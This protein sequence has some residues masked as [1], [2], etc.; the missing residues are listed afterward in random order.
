MIL[1]VDDSKEF[2]VID[3]CTSQ[4]YEQIKISYTRKV[5]NYKFNPRVKA[6]TWDGNISFI[7]GKTLPAST[8]KYLFDMCTEFGFDCEITNIET[9]F[10]NDIDYDEFVE[11]VNDFFKDN[12]IKPRYY[13]VD[14]AYQMLRAKRCCIML[15]TSAGKTLISFITISYLLTH[16]L[17]KKV[18]MIV[19]KIDLVLQ[20]TSDFKE[21]NNGKLDIKIQQIYSGCKVQPDANIYIGTYQSLC[22]ECQ[23]YFDQFDAVISDEVHLS[24]SA[25]QIKIMDMCKFPYR[26][27]LSGTIPT[28]KYA[29]GL[30]IMSNFGPIVSNVSAK[31]LQ[32]EGY[33]S[34]CKITQIRLDYTTES[35]K[36][37]FKLAKKQLTSIGKGKDMF[38]LENK[39][40]NES[41][42]RFNVI[43]KLIAGTDKNTLVLFQTKE[44]GKKI[45]KWLKENTSKQIYYIDGD[46]DKKVREE[47]RK[48]MEINHNAVLV[49]SFGTSSTGISINNIFNIFFVNSYKSPSTILQSIGRGL[50]K[51]EKIGKNF[52]K[53]FDISDDLYSGCYEMAHAR[54]RLKIY[55]GQYFP[56]EIRKLKI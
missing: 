54:E 9:L 55:E 13:Q 4:E 6:G 31:Q 7:K 48:R 21:Y 24:T 26:F 18:M 40:V 11:W 53:I 44:Y 50:R 34:N 41:E 29:D 17:A 49:A 28:T 25:S 27:G 46:I 3:S 16:N 43:T 8:Y 51:N 38:T 30:T 45:F 23:E 14:A 1:H 42:K 32:T 33:I 22:K 39:F 36:E 56:N 20:P 10:D 37:K 19:P 52:V 15:A 35:Q 12:P 5:K 2:L 47:I